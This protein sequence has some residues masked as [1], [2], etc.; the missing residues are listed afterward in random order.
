MTARKT[1]DRRNVVTLFV[2]FNDHSEFALR[3]H[4]VILSPCLLASACFALFPLR[5]PK[6]VAIRHISDR[7]FVSAV[8]LSNLR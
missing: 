7:N 2:A 1:R 6:E 4:K 8:T 5:T 3:F